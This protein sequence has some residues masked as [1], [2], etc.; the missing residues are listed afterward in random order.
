MQRNAQQ[1]LRCGTLSLATLIVG[2]LV[3]HCSTL[4]ACG[5]L[6]CGCGKNVSMITHDAVM[7]GHGC[8]RRGVRLSLPLLF[9]VLVDRGQVEWGWSLWRMWGRRPPCYFLQ[10]YLRKV[11]LFFVNFMALSLVGYCVGASTLL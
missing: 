1:S 6:T 7:R 4:S 8:V 10:A 3:K 5:A 9:L 11:E 2:L